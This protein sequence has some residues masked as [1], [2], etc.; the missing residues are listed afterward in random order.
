MR[1]N[2]Q[3]HRPF[4][5]TLR[6]SLTPERMATIKK[7][8][9]SAEGAVGKKEPFFTAGGNTDCTITVEISVE[10]PQQTRFGG[11]I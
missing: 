10:V 11:P 3:H 5:R 4:K 2:V 9:T 1:K 8:V 6:F 7:S